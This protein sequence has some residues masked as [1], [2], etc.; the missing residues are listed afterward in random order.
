VW[1][2]LLVAALAMA[3]FLMYESAHNAMLFFRVVVVGNLES[4]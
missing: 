1:L 4:G 3:W 2:H